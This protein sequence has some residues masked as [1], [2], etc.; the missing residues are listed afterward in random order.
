MVAVR[1]CTLQA[2]DSTA[3]WEIWTLHHPR[4]AF[5]CMETSPADLTVCSRQRVLL[6]TPLRK[7]CAAVDGTVSEEDIVSLHV[8]YAP[9]P[10][11]RFDVLGG[12]LK[13]GDDGA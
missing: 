13:Y 12:A 5:F 1:P 11:G 2:L 3:R 6:E 7:V 4:A 10:A 8:P 9:L